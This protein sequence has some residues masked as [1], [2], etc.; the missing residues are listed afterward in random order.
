[1]KKAIIQLQLSVIL[2]GFTGVFGRLISLNAGLITWYRLFISGILLLLI[3]AVTNKLKR[4]DPLSI[5]RI[6]F[7]GFLLGLHWL[8]FYGSIKYS[9]ISIGVVCFSLGSFFTAI[10]EPLI[11]RK[12]FSVP[13]LLLSGLTLCG[14]VLIFGL[15]ATYRLGITL[16]VISAIIVSFFTIFN[17]R[18]T[19][20]FDTQTITLY[21]MLGGCLGLTVIMP[22]Y[23]YISPVHSLLPSLP[24]WGYLLLLSLFCTVLMYLMITQALSKLSAFTV[25]LSFNLEPLYSIVLAILI[26]KENREFTWAFY[27]GLT[28]IIVSVVLQMSERG[29]I[30]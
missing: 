26:Y 17:E 5:L 2:A 6:A 1:M 21:E 14:I 7:T 15:D 11:N 29:I 13:E 19:K 28:L 23:L 20:E 30:P 4:M 22:L 25:S 8:F 9:N 16:G 10:F 18:L 12:K 3:M 27:V 24:D